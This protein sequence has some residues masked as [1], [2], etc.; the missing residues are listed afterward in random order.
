M[1]QDELAAVSL[2]LR[3]E[4]DWVEE[5][6]ANQWAEALDDYYRNNINTHF[7]LEPLDNYIQVPNDKK[8]NIIF[9]RRSQESLEEAW[10]TMAV[11]ELPSSQSLL[12]HQ[13]TFPSHPLPFHFHSFFFSA[14]ELSRCVISLFVSLHL[15]ERVSLLVHLHVCPIFPGKRTMNNVCLSLS[16]I[17]FLSFLFM[18]F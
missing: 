18:K 17:F 10:V 6:L 12:S 4:L 15:N 7:G 14:P 13:Q 3:V 2:R 16:F 1:M 11:E 5:N 9:P 8:I